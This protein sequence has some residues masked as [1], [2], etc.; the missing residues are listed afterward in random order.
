MSSSLGQL[1]RIP[2]ELRL[3]IWEWLLSRGS[4][5]F[6]ETSQ[7][8][9]QEISD[10]LYDTFDIHIS[11]LWEAPWVDIRCKRLRLRWHAKESDD[12]MLKKFSSI[13]YKKTRLAVHIWPP[14]PDDP[15]QIILLW[16]RVQSIVE[17]FNAS[18]SRK[19]ISIYLR[20]HDKRDWQKD[21]K[22]VES[23]PYPHLQNR[24]PD[25]NIVFLPFCC[26]RNIKALD[27]YPDSKTM[28]EAA[29]WGLI[30]YGRGYILNQGYNDCD[31]S[32]DPAY[33]DLVRVFDNIDALITD[34]DF[35]LDTQ[36]D[37]LSG[38]TA[39]ML[40]LAR[41]AKWFY[42]S[43]PSVSSYEK[44]HLQ[45]IREYKD[46]ISRH[47]PL[48]EKTLH[49]LDALDTFHVGVCGPNWPK[50]SDR[51]YIDLWYQTY[52]NGIPRLFKQQ[53]LEEQQKLLQ[54]GGIDDLR[55]SGVLIVVTLDFVMDVTGPA[56]H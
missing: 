38:R 21:G 2:P 37:T 3:I 6:L 26:L 43:D 52:P 50:M 11:P 27:V 5:R 33:Q 22:T 8:L 7:D 40:R 46:I 42:P 55:Q 56:R 9:Y 34:T 35:F 53:L 28:D 4:A 24:R 16:Q 44:R 20:T 12:P 41:F 47:D 48:L 1:G 49:R 19:R 29:D 32:R 25:F 14:D 15:G 30:N 23:I 45:I 54:G 36:M 17:V 10:R 39:P 31:H 18:K 13:P 51:Q